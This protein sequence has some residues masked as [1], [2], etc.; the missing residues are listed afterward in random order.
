MFQTVN[1]LLQEANIE[2]AEIKKSIPMSLPD[3][4]QEKDGNTR[5]PDFY[6]VN[7]YLES[8]FKLLQVNDVHA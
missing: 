7:D 2:E 6:G 4:N 1:E 3:L 8:V 5:Y